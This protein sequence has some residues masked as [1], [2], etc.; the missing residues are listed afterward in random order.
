MN[1]DSSIQEFKKYDTQDVLTSVRLFADQIEQAW[2]EAKENDLPQSCT[3]AKQI[4]I[5]GMGGSALGGRIIDTIYP[6]SLRTPLEVFSEYHIPNYVGS[7]TLVILSSYSGNT[8]ETL[9]AAYEAHQRHAQIFGIT[10]G[11]NL[12]NFLQKYNYPSYVFDPKNN[13][14]G[15]PRLG[16]GYSLAAMLSVLSRCEFISLSNEEM[17]EAIRSTRRLL[18][19]FAPDKEGSQNLT[20]SAAYA[21]KNKFPILVA[22]EHL[23]GAAYSFKNMLN[24]S[25]KTFSVIFDLPEM[26]HHLLEGLRNPASIKEH[27]IFLFFESDLYDN[28]VKKRYAI[29]SE[30]IKRNEIETISY[31]T[32]SKTRLEQAFEI[33][34]FGLYTQ[35]YLAMLYEIDPSPIP[36][37]DYLKQELAKNR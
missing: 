15:Q 37:V 17:Q 22:S 4:V 35:F 10:T 26:N 16:L 31:K 8:E 3:L 13:P 32:I 30:V 20:K 25:A 36:W 24:E 23:F 1:L 6:S 19:D 33:L 34:A 2:N 27:M 12:A 21:L 7:G 5:C 28:Q 11:G 18:S 14:S 9:S 29:T